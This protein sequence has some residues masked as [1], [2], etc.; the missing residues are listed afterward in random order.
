M[1]DGRHIANC[2]LAISRRYIGRLI[3]NLDCRRRITFRYWSREHNGN[4]RKFKM[5]DGRHF[6]NS[7]R[8]L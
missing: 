7:I 3:R 5:A 8:I 1:A 4:F 6:E 2:C